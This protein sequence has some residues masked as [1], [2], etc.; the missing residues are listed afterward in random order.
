MPAAKNSQSGFSLIEML[1]AIVILSVGLLGLAQLQVTA[2]KTNSQSMTS[3]AATVLAQQVIEEVAAMDAD[4]PLFD[5]PGSGTWAGSPVAI[6]GA[7]T[8]TIN[9]TV[10][11]VDPDND[12]STI[13]NVT[14]LYQVTVTVTSTT[15]VAHVLGNRQRQVVATTLR[16]AI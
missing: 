12:S 2:I 7:G 9:Y 5:A 1:V 16:R 10:A 3:T 14:N 15:D 13:N 11:E 8:Y 6:A 4:D